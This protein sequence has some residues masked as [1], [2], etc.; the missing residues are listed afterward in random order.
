MSPSRDQLG[1][2]HA[3]CRRTDS[4]R[5]DGLCR[6]AEQRRPGLDQT[7]GSFQSHQDR[8]DR[9]QIGGVLDA[10]VTPARESEP[11][12]AAASSYDPGHRAL[13]RLLPA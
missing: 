3:I 6:D 5:V 2:T 8:Y 1:E 13:D 9:S 11:A 4:S 12:I 10:E 7:N